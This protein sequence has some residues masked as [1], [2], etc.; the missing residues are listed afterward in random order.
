MGYNPY[1]PVVSSSTTSNVSLPPAP[2]SIAGRTQ[3]QIS[4][5]ADPFADIDE[6]VKF[7]LSEALDCLLQ[8]R[9]PV[10]GENVLS[11][12]SACWYNKNLSFVN[13][14]HLPSLVS[15]DMAKGKACINTAVKMLTNL[16]TN[17]EEAKFR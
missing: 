5:P 6:E 15:G 7:Q 17:P 16:A 1:Q 12:K 14:A 13:D 3:T 11:G 9:Q 8:Q 4:S 2:P 10:V